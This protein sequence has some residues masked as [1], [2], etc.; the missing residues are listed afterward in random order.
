MRFSPGKALLYVGCG[1]GLEALRYAR[2][3][4]GQVTGI[5]A[6]V[7]SIAEA[8]RRAA[9]AGLDAQFSVGDALGSPA[10]VKS[11]RERSRHRSASNRAH[12][13]RSVAEDGED[14]G[15]H[16]HSGRRR[17]PGAS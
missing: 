9:A 1:F 8:Q 14:H 6:S 7:D 3:G 4:K 12:E 5:D 11:N 13:G 10:H 2:A 16:A 17:K 15:L